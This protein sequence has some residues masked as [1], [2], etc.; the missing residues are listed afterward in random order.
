MAWMRKEKSRSAC[1]EKDGKEEAVESR[2][3]IVPTKGEQRNVDR[4]CK[5]SPDSLQPNKH[6]NHQKHRSKRSE[7]LITKR[8]IKLDD[9]HEYL[10]T[11]HCVHIAGGEGASQ[12][13]EAALEEGGEDVDEDDD[14]EGE[15]EEAILPVVGVHLDQD[16][17]GREE[18]DDQSQRPD[19]PGG[20]PEPVP[21]QSIKD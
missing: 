2:G 8:W 7:V 1:K 3:D 11:H 14:G 15:E 13:D 18:E 9:T 16:E 17:S 20:R 21:K 6:S 12:A 10:A 19:Q 5:H 4:R